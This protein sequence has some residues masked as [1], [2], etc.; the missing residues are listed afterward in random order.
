MLTDVGR[1]GQGCICLNPSQRCSGQGLLT[2]EG[3]GLGAGGERTRSGPAAP[4]T[5]QP[6]R[7]EEE[8]HCWEE[9]KGTGGLAVSS[10][11]PER[12][13]QHSRS[14][15]ATFLPWWM[16]SPSGKLGFNRCR[17]LLQEDTLLVTS[18][19][20]SAVKWPK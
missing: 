5:S 6:P 8:K 3:T 16:R 12:P 10:R 20:P 18:R 7:K 2:A 11:S 19:A 15:P 17:G 13:A 1:R 14:E 4:E 9:T